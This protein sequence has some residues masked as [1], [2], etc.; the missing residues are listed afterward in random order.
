MT[1]I[2]I[3]GQ[4][5]AP[6]HAMI[7]V[8][9][10]GLLYGDGLFEVLRTWHGAPVDLPAHLDRLYAS[11]EALARRAIDRGALAAAVHATL[12]A[13]G[14]GE[15][16]IRIVLTRGP[17]ALSAR[18]EELGPGRAIV[19]AEPLPELPTEVACA[20][21]D[22][23]LP[24]RPGPAHKSLAYLDHIVA[25]DLARAAGADEAL[26]L[27]GQGLVVEGATSNVHVVVDGT[28]VSPPAAAGALPGVVRGR[29][30]AAAARL[31]IAVREDRIT[32]DQL[33]AADEILLTS[34][35]RG[36]VAVT[37]LDGVARVAGRTTARLAA[38]V[39]EEVL[40]ALA[41]R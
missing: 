29:L 27:D 30:L 4:L 11:A 3:D 28:L 16:R 40:A 2:S 18:T 1:A 15:Q 41:C 20:V 35:L 33:R 8:L 17:G 5:V 23:P 24:R 26:R 21:V 37:R 13:A 6:E 10:R 22:W 14:A 32:V 7:S 25:R 34:S 31:G 19:I 36:V 12:A 38:A 9:D 39:R